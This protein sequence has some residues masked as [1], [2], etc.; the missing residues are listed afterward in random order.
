[1]N[2]ITTTNAFLA[3]VLASAGLA[4]AHGHGKQD[5]KLMREAA[6]A[7]ETTSPDLSARLKDCAD[8]ATKKG[9]PSMTEQAELREA[10]LFRDSAAAL[11]D[12]RPDLSKRLNRVADKEIRESSSRPSEDETPRKVY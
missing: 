5:I 1:M 8:G 10:D 4:Q 11:K 7:L 2:K 6:A 12:S 9:T 3:L